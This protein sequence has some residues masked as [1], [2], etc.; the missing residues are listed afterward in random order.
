MKKKKKIFLLIGFHYCVSAIH[1]MNKILNLN[2]I[3]FLKVTF[4]C[5]NLEIK[6]EKKNTVDFAT[7]MKFYFAFKTIS[8]INLVFKKYPTSEMLIR[9]SNPQK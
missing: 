3:Y 8:K 4:Q 1:F 5:I 9:Y 2:Q 6:N 7:V